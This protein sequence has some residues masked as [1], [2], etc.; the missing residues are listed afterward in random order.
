MGD[1]ASE[2]RARVNLGN[3]YFKLGEVKKAIEH[4]ERHMKIAKKVADKAG[5]GRAYANLGHSYHCLGNDDKAIQH[6]ELYLQTSKE[7]GDKAGE[8]RAHGNLGNGYHSLGD[9]KKA[10]ECHERHLLISREVGDKAGE[11]RAYGKLGNG[12]HSFGDFKKAMECHEQAI[13]HHKRHLKISKKVGER[14]G[15]GRAFG[16]RGNGY[17]SLSDFKQALEHHERYLEICSKVGDKAGEGQA[18]GNLGNDYDRLAWRLKKAI[19]H[20]ERHLHI[21]KE[22]GDKA[23]EGRAYANLGIGYI[24]LG[25]FQKVIEHHELHLEIAKE[26]LVSKKLSSGLYT[27]IR[28][29]DLRR[30]ELNGCVSEKQVREFISTLYYNALEE[31]GVRTAVSCENCSLYENDNQGLTTEGDPG[32]VSRRA[33]SKRSLGKL[34]EVIIAPI[35]NLVHGDDFILVP[36]GPFCLVPFAALVYMNMQYLS[37]TFRIRV[38]PSLTT[39]QLVTDCPEDFHKKNGALLVGDPCLEE[40]LFNGIKLCQLSCAKKE[41]EVIGKILDTT[42]LIGKMATK[43]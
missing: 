13:E 34:Y 22:V 31:I 35:A 38:I 9:F 37:E 24:A 6:H 17:H 21:S 12:Y 19:E 16:N 11:G 30:K 27:A 36:E 26:H 32:Q 43:D 1:K 8:R 10:M 7:V 42:P 29:V 39:L 20:H 25:D 33:S 2:G 23:I 41:E 28:T 3:G 4:H 40:V 15:E 5:E 18:Y 14:A